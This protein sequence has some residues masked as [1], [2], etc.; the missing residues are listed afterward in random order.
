VIDAT[1]D[2]LMSL[3]HSRGEGNLSMSNS[4]IASNLMI[5]AP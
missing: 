1:I 3:Q 4:N 5:I 2:G